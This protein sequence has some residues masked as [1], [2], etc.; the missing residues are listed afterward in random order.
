MI[1]GAIKNLHN[2]FG[3]RTTAYIRLF[4]KQSPYTHTVLEDLAKFCR[5]DESTFHPD[6]RIHATLEGRREV[7]L[8]IQNFL[9]LTPDEL[10][11]YHRARNMKEE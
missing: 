2:Y 9:K 11:N 3:R 1:A 6:S 10:V 5:A 8:R 7:W 4:D